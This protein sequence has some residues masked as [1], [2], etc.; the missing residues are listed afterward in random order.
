MKIWCSYG[1]EHSANLVMIGHF[2]TISDASKA[3]DAIEL[4]KRRVES[5]VEAGDLTIGNP[6]THFS[7]AMLDFLVKHK[8]H[9]FAPSELEQFVYDISIK[10]SGSDVIITTDE[11]EIA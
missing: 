2:E 5:D 10:T 9:T 6:P 1:T 7:D 11:I 8:M 4:I 3:H